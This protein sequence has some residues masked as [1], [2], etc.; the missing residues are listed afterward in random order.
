MNQSAQ[1]AM[2]YPHAAV[3]W[4]RFDEGSGTVAGDSSGYG[5]DGTLLPTGSEPQWVDGKYDKALSFDGVND[6]VNCG[7]KPNL[8]IA[9]NQIT[10]SA[11]V[12]KAA[13]VPVGGGFSIISKNRYSKYFLWI[14]DSQKPRFSLTTTTTKDLDA[15]TV[16]VSDTWYYLSAVYNGSTMKIYVNGILENE[17]AQS[18]NIA[19]TTQPLTIGRDLTYGLWLMNGVI[20]E[21]RVYNRALSAPE[22]QT[23]FQNPDFSSRFLAKVPKGTTQVITTLSWQG[24]GAINVTIQSPSENYTEAIVP[25]YQKTVYSASGGTSGM[26][27][28][29]R[30]SVS[31]T[32]ALSTDEN[33]YVVLEFDDVEDYKLTVEVQK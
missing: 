11:W 9:G 22:V 26:L 13:A 29:K 16:T 8:E 6:Y 32:A 4:W 2:I 18:G 19:S 14:T 5:N 31:L 27:N 7:N 10:L 33:W 15:T 17:I 23:E 25:V 21:V 30:L 24:I 12:K 28:I 20:D 1:A 3:G